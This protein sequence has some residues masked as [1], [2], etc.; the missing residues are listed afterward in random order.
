[1]NDSIVTVMEFNEPSEA[2]I[3][4]GKLEAEGI[5]CNLADEKL[6]QNTQ[7][8]NTHGPIRLQ[9]KA[10]DAEKAKEILG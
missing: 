7:L 10:E 6:V 9:V 8:W 4:K 1:M 2:H 5:Q 3:C